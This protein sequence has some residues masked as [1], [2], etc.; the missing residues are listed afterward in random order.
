MANEFLTQCEM[1]VNAAAGRKLSDD[2]M[3]SLVR[4]MNDTT[5]RILAGN[6]ALTLEEAAMRVASNW[7]KSLR[8]GIRPLIPVLQLSALA[9]FAGL[10]KTVL[11]SVW[12][13]F[14]SDVMTRALV[15]A[16]R[17][18]LRWPNCAVSIMLVSTMISTRQDWLNLL[19]VAAMTAR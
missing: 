5:N 13:L 1:T 15:P 17:Y 8:H 11:T 4:D 16:A 3:E 14:L 18:P 6:E 2:E 12:R 9:S 7:L 19:P 10:G